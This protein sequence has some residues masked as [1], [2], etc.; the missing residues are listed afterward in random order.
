MS[1]TPTDRLTNALDAISR[2]ANVV[3]MPNLRQRYDDMQ[4]DELYDAQIVAD[5]ATRLLFGPRLSDLTFTKQHAWI[6]GAAAFMR[7]MRESWRKVANDAAVDAV[8]ATITDG[9]VGALFGTMKPEKQR[10]IARVLA[11]A[12]VRAHYNVLSGAT[13]LPIGRYLEVAIAAEHETVTRL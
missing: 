3:P 6:S 5:Q 8:A 13:P 10:A 4:R 9:D 1:V 2:A 12:A 7:R 11:E